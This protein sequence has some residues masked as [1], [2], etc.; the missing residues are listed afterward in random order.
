MTRLS[1]MQVTLQHTPPS[2]N[3]TAVRLVIFL[4]DINEWEL[5]SALL[6][7]IISARAVYLASTFFSEV[8]KCD[9]EV[10]FIGQELTTPP[11]PGTYLL[12]ELLVQV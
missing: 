8:I 1:C 12:Q 6:A 7:G 4:K 9:D 5:P 2:F 11:D 3:C 10:Y